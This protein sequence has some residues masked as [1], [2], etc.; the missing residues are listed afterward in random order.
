MTIGELKKRLENYPDDH[1][2]VVEYGEDKVGPVLF[3]I[4]G[5]RDS[6]DEFQCACNARCPEPNAVLLETTY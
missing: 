2:A 4:E 5:H 6:E 3:V 1:E